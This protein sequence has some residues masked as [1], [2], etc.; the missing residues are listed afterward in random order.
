MKKLSLLLMVLTSLAFVGSAKAQVFYST[1]FDSMTPGSIFGQDGWSNLDG[2]NGSN[3]VQSVTNAASYSGSQ[4]WLLSSAYGESNDGTILAIAAPSLATAG[5]SNTVFGGTPAYNQY[6]ESFWFRSVATSDDPGL[7]ISSAIGSP[8]SVRNTWLGIYEDNGGLYVGNYASDATGNFGDNPNATT[9]ALTW[10]SWYQVKVSANFIN[11]PDNDQV[12]YQVLDANGNVLLNSTIGSWE[13]YY[14]NDPT[15]EDAPGPVPSNRVT[16]E[17]GGQST[18]QGIYIDN[19]SESV[20]STP[21]PSAWTLG[22]LSLVLFA[23]LLRRFKV[24]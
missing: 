14:A 17:L 21:E 22:L 18:D 10:G 23:V 4:S 6:N 11:G 20:A 1:D 7:Y 12:N 2:S 8:A 24:A 5:E 19:F 16:F 15:A 9:S 3:Y 13:T